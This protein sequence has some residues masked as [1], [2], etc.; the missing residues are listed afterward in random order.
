M[1][2]RPVKQAGSMR[3]DA[4]VIAWLKKQGKGYQTRANRI[5]EAAHARGNSPCIRRRAPVVSHPFH[6][7]R[8]KEGQSAP[9]QSSFTS[10]RW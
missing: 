9:F 1:F 5:P 8:C 2:Y 4:D 7:T 10:G 3:L 6:K